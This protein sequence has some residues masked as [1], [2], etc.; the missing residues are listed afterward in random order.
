MI[1]TLWKLSAALYFDDGFYGFVG[2][3]WARSLV[4]HPLIDL[5]NLGYVHVKVLFRRWKILTSPTSIL[6]CRSIK[7]PF[8]WV[9]NRSRWCLIQCCHRV[10]E[11]AFFYVV[12]WSS[13]L[14]EFLVK[15]MFVFCEKLGF[16]FYLHTFN[17]LNMSS[18]HRTG[19]YDMIIGMASHI[20]GEA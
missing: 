5:L 12:A 8:L 10:M 16:L 15:R 14:A 17:W 11:I 2:L 13:A 9:F 4:L 18:R 3:T 20:Y 6:P 7:S 19:S 1:P